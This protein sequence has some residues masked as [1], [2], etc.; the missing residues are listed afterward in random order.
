MLLFLAVWV[1]A[2]NMHTRGAGADINAKVFLLCSKSLHCVCVSGVQGVLSKTEGYARD[3][4]GSSLAGLDM[5]DL[6]VMDSI[7]MSFSS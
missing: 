7:A 1:N 4:A 5:S 2:A 3:V 6:D